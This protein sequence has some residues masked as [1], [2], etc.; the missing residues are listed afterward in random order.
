MI[1]IG[2][3]RCLNKDKGCKKHRVGLSMQANK[4]DDLRETKYCKEIEIKSEQMGKQFNSERVQYACVTCNMCKIY[5]CDTMVKKVIELIPAAEE[6]L[7][8]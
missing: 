1:T 2:V 8:F 7:T 5:K 4:I 6:W 3:F